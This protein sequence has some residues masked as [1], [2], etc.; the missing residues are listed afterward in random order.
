MAQAPVGS[1]RLRNVSVINTTTLDFSPAFY[2]NGIVYVSAE[3]AEGKS[4]AYDNRINKNAMSLFLSQRDVNGNLQK[5]EPFT[6]DAESSLHEGPLCFD[7]PNDI[8]Y[9]CRNDSKKGGNKNGGQAQFIDGFSYMKI[10]ASQKKA[11]VWSSAEELPVNADKS[12]ACH[13]SISDDGT[14]LYFASNR[15]GGY[16]GMDIYMSEKVNGIWSKPINLGPKINTAANEAFPFIHKSGVLFYS[17]QDNVT[18]WDIYH[19]AINSHGVYEIPEKMPIPINSEN[20]DF[21]F[22]LDTDNQTGFL[23]S[24]RKGGLGEDDIYA[25]TTLTSFDFLVRNDEKNDFHTTMQNKDKSKRPLS[26]LAVDRKTGRRLESVMISAI[27]LDDKGSANPVVH[28]FVT[29]IKGK[30][31]LSLDKDSHYILRAGN[32]TFVAS[33]MSFLKEDD[34]TEMVILL[35]EK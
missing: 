8:V 15:A 13:P 1:I 35:D 26:I 4:K 17:S 20:D 19:T 3:V 29:N 22:I 14:R 6:L 30:T 21:G 5:S 28:S 31:I 10:Y 7:V 24:N 9:F 27:Q 18:G 12:D 23:T 11:N 2:K 33:D 16:G 34:E 25:F 32:K